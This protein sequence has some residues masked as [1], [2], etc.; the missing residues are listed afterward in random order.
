LLIFTISNI[1]LA[2]LTSIIFY[3][4]YYI[5]LSNNIKFLQSKTVTLP[6]HHMHIIIESENTVKSN[7]TFENHSC[8]Y[9]A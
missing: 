1:T 7:E 6:A 8:N 5:N 3:Y 2:H 4:L 9:H